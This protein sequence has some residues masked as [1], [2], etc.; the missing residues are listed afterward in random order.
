MI[1]FEIDLISTSYLMVCEA[2]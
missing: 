1:D 2:A